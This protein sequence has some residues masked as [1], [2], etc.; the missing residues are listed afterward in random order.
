MESSDFNVQIITSHLFRQILNNNQLVETDW[1]I[2]LQ[3]IWH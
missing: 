2:T 3:C 1:L